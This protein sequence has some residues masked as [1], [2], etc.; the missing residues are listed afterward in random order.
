MAPCFGRSRNY[1]IWLVRVRATRWCLAW[2]ERVA[3]AHNCPAPISPPL[4]STMLFY[5]RRRIAR[6]H[7]RGPIAPGIRVRRQ[8]R[9]TRRGSEE[10]RVGKE[11]VRTGRSRGE[12]CTEKKNNIQPQTNKSHQRAKKK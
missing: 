3:A 4:Q 1:P 6:F 10:S 8:N 5:T 7:A 2:K 11:W 9:H 12:Q